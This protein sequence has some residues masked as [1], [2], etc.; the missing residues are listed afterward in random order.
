M[1]FFKPKMVE[2]SN[3]ELQKCYISQKKAEI[4]YNKDSER[5]DFLQKNRF[6]SIFQFFN[7]LPNARG[8]PKIFDAQFSGTFKKNFKNGLSGTCLVPKGTKS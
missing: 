5:K 3:F 1:K 7:F 6:F 4:I 8:P 2:I